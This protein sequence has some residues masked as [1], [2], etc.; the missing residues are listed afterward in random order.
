[1][2]VF[3]LCLLL[4]SAGTLLLA[5]DVPMVTAILRSVFCLAV[6]MP[7]CPIYDSP[8]AVPCLG[9]RILQSTSV[10]PAGEKSA[11]CHPPRATW[12][13]LNKVTCSWESLF[14][15]GVVHNSQV[16]GPD[17]T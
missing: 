3:G 15:A 14:S 13:E 11:Q 4:L 10:W 7:L 6:G 12:T 5:E 9:C 17:I 1:M 16:H 2:L 8:N